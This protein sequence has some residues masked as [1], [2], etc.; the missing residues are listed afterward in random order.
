MYIDIPIIII[1]FPYSSCIS[2]FF[3][4]ASLFLCSFFKNPSSTS[5]DDVKVN[6]PNRTYTTITENFTFTFTDYRTVRLHVALENRSDLHVN[7]RQKIGHYR[8]RSTGE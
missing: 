5:K 7:E 3:A 8:T 2:S 1:T 4:A 6:N